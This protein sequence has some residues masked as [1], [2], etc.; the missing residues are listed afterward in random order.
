MMAIEKENIVPGSL[1]MIQLFLIFTDAELGQG[2][3]ACTTRRSPLE[4][5]TEH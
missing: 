2:E 4:R 1:K 5:T 3:A